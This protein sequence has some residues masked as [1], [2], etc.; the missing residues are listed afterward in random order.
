MT[1][2]HDDIAQIALLARI[3]IS[4][5]EKT[6]YHKELSSIVAYFA[7]LQSVDTATTED[8]GHITGVTDV[9]RGDVVAEAPP[10]VRSAIMAQVP[11]V[12]DEHIAVKNIL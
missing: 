9:V 1:L 7:Q 5:E 3:G 10:A 12:R 6:Q 8:I 11:D 2:T 4:D